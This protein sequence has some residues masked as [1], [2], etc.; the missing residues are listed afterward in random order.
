MMHK[1]D[2]Y[3]ISLAQFEPRTCTSSSLPCSPPTL[4]S[5]IESVGLYKHQSDCTQFM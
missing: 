3:W 5:L 4:N 1:G 2:S